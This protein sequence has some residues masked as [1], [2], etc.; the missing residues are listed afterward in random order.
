MPTYNKIDTPE[1]KAGV[2]TLVYE[3]TLSTAA[4]SVTISGL[5]GNTDEVYYLKMMFNNTSDSNTNVKLRINNDSTASRYGRQYLEGQNST[6]SAARDTADGAYIAY[7]TA[8]NI[9]QSENTIYAKT[10]NERLILSRY[11]GTINGTTVTQAVF[12][13][14]SYNET[15]TNLTSI[16]LVAGAANALGV[17]TYIALYRRRAGL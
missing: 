14:Y 1:L 8:G 6:A 9:S 4:S 17:G 11:S 16:V 15:S 3:T 5:D 2:D 7:A 10:G 13:G 12:L